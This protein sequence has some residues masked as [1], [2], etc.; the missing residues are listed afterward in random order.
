MVLRLTLE[1]AERMPACAQGHTDHARIVVLLTELVACFRQVPHHSGQY[2]GHPSST[3]APHACDDLHQES[4]LWRHPTAPDQSIEMLHASKEVESTGCGSKPTIGQ[5]VPTAS[6]RG[7]G[8]L[9]EIAARLNQSATGM[10]EAAQCQEMA[11]KDLKRLVH[12]QAM[13][14]DL[15]STENPFSLLQSTS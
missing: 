4:L 6:N 12:M 11:L 8:A 15:A 9:V 3:V 13:Q 1:V 2:P 7:R 14:V 10:V 5:G